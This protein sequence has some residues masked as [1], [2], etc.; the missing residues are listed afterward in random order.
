MLLFTAAIVAPLL[1]ISSVQAA[2]SGKFTGIGLAGLAG[3]LDLT[4]HDAHKHANHT[5]SAI[6]T[7]LNGKSINGCNVAGYPT[8]SMQQMMR[9]QPF[10]IKSVQQCQATCWRDTA[11]QSYSYSPVNNTCTEYMSSLDVTSSKSSEIYFSAKF[12]SDGSNFCYGNSS[13]TALALDS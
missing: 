4:N 8:D 6:R 5:L 13:E 1:V 12:T 10:Q 7:S 3:L 2:P 11:C 9:H